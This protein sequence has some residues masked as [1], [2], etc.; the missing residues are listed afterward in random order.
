MKGESCYIVS[1]CHIGKMWYHEH[2]FL[3]WERIM[4]ENKERFKADLI[5][6]MESYYGKSLEESSTSEKYIVLANMVRSA[7]NESW[8]QS[9][10]T[11]RGNHEKQMYYFSLEFL[12]GRMLS[13]NLMNLG[14]YGV[15]KE[16]LHDLGIDLNELEDVESDAGLGNGGLGRLA[17]CFLDSLASMGYAGNGNTIRYQYGLFKQLIIN[18]EQVEVP[19]QWLKLGNPWEVRK[20]DKAVTIRFYG[21]VNIS[22][23]SN[24]QL[25]FKHVDTQDVIAVPYDMPI[26]GEDRRQT[27]TLRMWS[28]EP[29]DQFEGDFRKY[30]GKVNDICLNVYPDDSTVEGRYLRIKQEYFFVSAG[31]HAII[32]E[33]MRIYGT[34]SNFH[35][36]VV[37]QLNDTHPALAIPELM[38]I[39][40][41]DYGYDWDHAL[42]I[43]S[44]TFAYTNHTVMA[45]ALEKWPVEYIRD[46]LPRI[47]L[48]IEELDRKFAEYVYGTGHSRDFLN[49]VSIISGDNN[50][51]MAHLS[52]I[53]SFSVNGVAK[54]HSEILKSDLFK[55]FYELYPEKF[56]NKTNGITHRRWLLHS[57][58][59]LVQ[60][61]EKYI[62]SDFKN[63]IRKLGDLLQK[64]DD[65]ELQKEFLEVKR[66]RKIA[67]A[68]YLHREYDIEI[69]PNSIFDTI[70]KRLHAYK[71]QLLDIFH[72]IYLY[73]RL[74]EDP[75]FKIEKT[76]F[77]FA[78][79]AAS[80]YTLAKKII[81][82][83]N[84]VA[85]V[86]DNDSYVSQY[87]KV[88]F[89]PNY[90]VT[91][92]EKLMN[93]SDISEQ[94][95]TAGKE[96]SGTGNMK[97]MMNGAVTLGTM[98]GANVEIHEL[99][100]D[101]NIEIFGLRADEVVELKH[102]YDPYQYYLNDGRLKRI[103]DS[104]V[105]GTFTNDRNDF[106]IIYDDLLAKGDEY[107]VLADFD[108][109]VRAH[110]HLYEIYADR[111]RFARMCLVN[112]ARSAYFSSDR[113]IREYAREIWHIEPVDHK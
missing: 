106:R 99:V 104:L 101:D 81:K 61:L 90:R 38:R 97:F 100:G 65:S 98:D 51:R 108:A 80:S 88:V 112:I 14:A 103:V 71:R 72:V 60:L 105:D 70:A 1:C 2:D 69:D 24:G 27:N 111:S 95:S 110:E 20:I 62:G 96:A 43:V 57:N 6:N 94:I 55:D 67:L 52:I 8:R 48:I 22:R 59:Q 91:I 10:E 113:T 7:V 30:L 28:A 19:D 18:N 41:D 84:C 4:F 3:S 45:E 42:Y 44:N 15:V 50:V 102:H 109:Y 23:D 76:T 92:A 25:V 63:D 64:V 47:Y 82:L 86:I 9:K 33:H 56:N 79:K 107:C 93:A 66:Q 17:A 37:I 26:V 89:I 78:A 32:R 35:E 68:D 53:G 29:S 49:R 21:H 39:L 12:M 77:I 46:L 11:T 5:A 40:M 58:P 34:L 54:L 83:I 87:I 36:K 13:N 75:N 31:L 73:F 16:G 74:K 85:S